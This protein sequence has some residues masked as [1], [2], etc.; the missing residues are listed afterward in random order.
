MFLVVT[1]SCYVALPGLDL[2][3]QTM[4]RDLSASVFCLL[5]LSM[6]NPAHDVAILKVNPAPYLSAANLSWFQSPM[7]QGP[8]W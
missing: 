6:T 3:I 5:G 2:A 4:H 8:D 7:G 1:R